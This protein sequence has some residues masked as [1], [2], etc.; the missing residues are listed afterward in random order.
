MGGRGEMG[1]CVK[2]PRGTVVEYG[3]RGKELWKWTEREIGKREREV[4]GWGRELYALM[5][6]SASDGEGPERAVDA[7]SSPFC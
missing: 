4:Q 3:K 7:E 2:A 6:E 1:G 5:E